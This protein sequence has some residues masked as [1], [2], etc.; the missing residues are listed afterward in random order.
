MEQ[1]SSYFIET[2][3]KRYA[4]FNGRATR[5]EFWYFTLFYVLLSFTFVAIDQFVVNPMLG[6]TASQAAQGGLLQFIF[7]LALLIP[8]LSVGVRRLHDIGKSGWWMLLSLVPLLGILVLIY[9]WVQKSQ[10]V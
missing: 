5:S 9:F 10:E 6:M 1:F 3:K 4:D 2:V 7:A 8:S